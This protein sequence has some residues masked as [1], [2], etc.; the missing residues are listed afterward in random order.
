MCLC[1]CVCACVYSQDV[2]D[3]MPWCEERLVQKVLFLSLKEFRAARRTNNNNSDQGPHRPRR[4]GPTVQSQP[5]QTRPPKP[6]AHHARAKKTTN[7]TPVPQDVPNTKHGS[8]R[9]PT[10]TLEN[11]EEALTPLPPQMSPDTCSSASKCDGL[12]ATQRPV[13]VPPTAGDLAPRTGREVTGGGE[14]GRSLASSPITQARTLRSHKAQ[15]FPAYLNASKPPC[16]VAPQTPR[17]DAGPGEHCAEG[18]NGAYA[19]PSTST[20]TGPTRILRSHTPTTRLNGKKEEKIIN[21]YV[22]NQI[23]NF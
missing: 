6:R 15:N 16:Q 20:P 5:R 11:T 10:R 17:V 14:D 3:G 23:Q 9:W 19:A 8:V 2:S 7:K 12:R 13:Q 21:N 18:L 4:G 22:L 1:V